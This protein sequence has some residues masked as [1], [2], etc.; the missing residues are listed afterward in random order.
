[1]IFIEQKVSSFIHF[2]VSLSAPP[3]SFLYFPLCLC[4]SWENGFLSTETNWNIRMLSSRRWPRLISQH[5]IFLNKVYICYVPCPLAIHIPYNWARESLISIRFWWC[6]K[7]V[8]DVRSLHTW[9]RKSKSLSFLI[10]LICCSVHVSMCA[11]VLYH[12]SSSAFSCYKL[13]YDVY[14]NDNFSSYNF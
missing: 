6:W 13:Y 4:Q 3:F 5:N 1:M 7:L 14:W 2:Q 10:L 11:S 12:F 9:Y 8:A